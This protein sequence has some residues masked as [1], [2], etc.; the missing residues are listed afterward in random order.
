MTIS[1]F[2]MVIYYI[3][4]KN[5]VINQRRK[6][7][8]KKTIIERIGDFIIDKIRKKKLIKR[9]IEDGRDVDGDVIFYDDTV[10]YVH[11]M[12]KYIKRIGEC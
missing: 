3:G 9:A 4:D 5:I 7:M 10:Y 12:K 6:N 11:I 2:F 8:N 1:I